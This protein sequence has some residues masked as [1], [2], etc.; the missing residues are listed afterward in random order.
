ME[1]AATDILLIDFVLVGF[2]NQL[3]KNK[4]H[5]KL[6]M[7]NNYGLRTFQTLV[8]DTFYFQIPIHTQDVPA[9]SQDIPALY[10]ETFNYATN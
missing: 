2:M 3:I 5:V 4:S 9:V 1:F 6:G 8:N 7:I 10:A